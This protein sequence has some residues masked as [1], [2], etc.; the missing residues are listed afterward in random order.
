V[1]APRDEQAGLPSAQESLRL[2][3]MLGQARAQWT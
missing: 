2:F 3:Q 1:G